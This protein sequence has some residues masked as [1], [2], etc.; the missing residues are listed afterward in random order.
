MLALEA[1]ARV[2]ALAKYV[3]RRIMMRVD[4]RPRDAAYKEELDRVICKI[5]MVAARAVLFFETSAAEMQEDLINNSM[6]NDETKHK[7]IK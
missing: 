3:R 7:L 2:I 1:A 6:S 5:W 4:C